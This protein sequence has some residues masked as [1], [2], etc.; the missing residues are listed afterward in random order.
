MTAMAEHPL[1]CGFMSRPF[2]KVGGVFTVLMGP[3]AIPPAAMGS[4]A[5]GYATSRDLAVWIAANLSA[6][7][8]GGRQLAGQHIMCMRWPPVRR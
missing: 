5:F 1:V 3:T 2:S 8:E 6:R 4:A 7:A